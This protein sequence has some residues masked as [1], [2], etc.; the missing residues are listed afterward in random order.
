MAIIEVSVSSNVHEQLLIIVFYCE[1]M[2]FLWW[3]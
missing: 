3:K 1:I 2:M